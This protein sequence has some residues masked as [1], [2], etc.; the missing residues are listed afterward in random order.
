MYVGAMYIHSSIGKSTFG[1][2]T[3]IQRL[4]LHSEVSSIEQE[5]ICDTVKPE[6]HSK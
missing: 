1:T 5:Q 2:P 4:V 3:S 6:G